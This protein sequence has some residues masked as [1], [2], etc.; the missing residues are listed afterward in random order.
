VSDGPADFP[1]RIDPA[2]PQPWLHGP[3]SGGRHQF[4]ERGELKVRIPNP[5]KNGSIDGALVKEILRQT[6]IKISDWEN[7]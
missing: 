1:Q 4:V 6:G 3:I 2:F 7:A 5:H